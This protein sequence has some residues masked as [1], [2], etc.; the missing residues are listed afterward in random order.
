MAR[1]THAVK[2]TP[3]ALPGLPECLLVLPSDDAE[4]VDAPRLVPDRLGVTQ[5][6]PRDREFG[7]PPVARPGT[8]YFPNTAPVDVEFAA[9]IRDQRLELGT[10]RVGRED[11]AAPV[12]MERVEQNRDGVV[13]RKLN[14]RPEEERLDELVPL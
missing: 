7:A 6:P 11:H 13:A 2:A 14:A 12:V 1:A 9:L 8:P 4:D 3:L 5:R 10:V